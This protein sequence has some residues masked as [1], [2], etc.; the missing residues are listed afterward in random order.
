MAGRPRNNFP[1][2]SQ[3]RESILTRPERS[4]PHRQSEVV[5][6]PTSV[7]CELADVFPLPERDLERTVVVSAPSRGGAAEHLVVA[8]PSDDAT[9]D[10]DR[11]VS[12]PVA[13]GSPFTG[14]ATKQQFQVSIL[15]IEF[16]ELAEK[17]ITIVAG[18]L[19]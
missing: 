1:V 14:G 4:G 3:D 19:A 13:I 12:V 16:L 18:R 2:F 10:F 7:C 17:A 6:R 9:L 5:G 11:I 8:A 15:Q